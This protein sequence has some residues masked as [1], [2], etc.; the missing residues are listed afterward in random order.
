MEEEKWDP[1]IIHPEPDTSANEGIDGGPPPTWDPGK[2][3]QPQP[4]EEEDDQAEG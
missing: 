4:E 1:K 3:T 2:V